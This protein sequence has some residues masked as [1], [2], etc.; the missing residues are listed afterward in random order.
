MQAQRHGFRWS[1]EEIFQLRME[2]ASGM[3]FRDIAAKH[4]RSETAIR[5]R[6]V[7]NAAKAFSEGRDFSIEVAA[8]RFHV[9]PKEVYE[10]LTKIQ[11]ID[12]QRYSQWTPEEDAELS[13]EIYKWLPQDSKDPGESASC[14]HYEVIAT[15]HGRSVD[16]IRARII[17]FALQDIQKGIPKDKVVEKYDLEP[18]ALDKYLL[19]IIPEE[20]S[21]T[22]LTNF[23]LQIPRGSLSDNHIDSLQELLEA[24]RS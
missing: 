12:T 18:N 9:T 21:F 6:C 16:A 14:S 1:D 2:V 17:K 11:T 20:I 8:T 22:S 7:I 24:L 4:D 15:N 3:S 5:I 13:L 10:A 23:I 19:N